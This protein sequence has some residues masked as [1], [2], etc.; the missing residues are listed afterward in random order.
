M[1]EDTYNAITRV[2]REF[3]AYRYTPAHQHQTIGDRLRAEWPELWQHLDN[4][5]LRWLE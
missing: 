4:L 5:Q 2:A 1:T 3:R